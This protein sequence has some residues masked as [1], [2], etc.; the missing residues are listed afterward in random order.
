MKHINDGW[1][2]TTCAYCGVGCGVEARPNING[3]LEIR[4]DKEHPANFGKLCT[5]G[6][7]L[8]ETVIT[9]GRLL[10]PTLKTP[11]GNETTDWENATTIV[12]E[13][14]K[15]TI[16]EFGPDSVAFYVSGQLLTE[17]YYL[18]N[19][20]IKGFIGTGNID[21][22]SR[23]CMASSVVGHKR[24]FGTDTVPVCYEDIEKSNLVILVGSNL[25]WCHPVIFQR[26]R[27]A[28][29]NNPDLKV[30]V[31]D[32]R[33]SETCAIADL[34]LPIK[35]G[36][37]VALFNGLLSYLD[38]TN[39]L[40]QNYIN[41]YTNNFENALSSAN[42]ESDIENKTGLSESQLMKFY[43]CFSST[44]K[45]ITIYSQG[46]NQ[47]TS[48][49][50]KVNSIINCHLATGKI[51]K[52]GTGPFSITGQPNA[53]GGRE[54]GALANTLASHMEFDN[55]EHTQLISEFWQTDRLATKAGLKAVDMFN[56]IE[57][58]K[59]KAIWI[60]AT[61]PVISLPNSEKIKSALETCP[62]V[63]VSDCIEETETT[64]LAD[65]VLPAQGWSE[66]SGTVT[67][68]ERRIS[69]QRRVMPSPGMAKP[70]WWIINQVAR[71]MGFEKSF[72][73]R[74]EGEI[75][76]E[77]ARLSTVGNLN[78]E[79][80]FN[81]IGLTNLDDKGYSELVPQ[82]WPVLALQ[83]S[84]VNQ[85]MFVDNLFFTSNKKANF[86]PTNY[87]A[88]KS[89]TT[90]DFPMLLNSGRTRDQ[91]HTM[92]RTG[93]SESL[94]DHS[95]EPY[96]LISK[97]S[98][99]LYRIEEGQ[100]VKLT[101]SVGSCEAKAKITNAI[102]DHQLFMPI[103]WTNITA[104]N[105]KPCSLIGS[106]NDDISGQPEFKHTPVCI[107]PMHS[108]SSAVFITRTPVN[109][110]QFEY[111]SRQKI[112]NGYLYRI[113]SSLQVEELHQLL[114]GLSNNSEAKVLSFDN[115]G[116]KRVVALDADKVL[117]VIQS[118]KDLTCIDL[119]Q[120]I[121]IFEQQVDLLNQETILAPNYDAY[122]VA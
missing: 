35:S 28:K 30:I 92:S 122:E 68:S 39:K 61:N 113:E 117:R 20:L 17:D 74:H 76:A 10:S 97:N 84:P 101:S 69:R 49:S 78:N 65:L 81:L 63:V 60:M 32:P 66:K 85:R 103:H 2:K 37:D 108:I 25:A 120:L 106:Q 88:P 18:A 9:D 48:G 7:A 51:G 13:R 111:W 26:L 105:S 44:E 56:A 23:L 47:S 53:M 64:R 38:Q 14:F 72:N 55:T 91:W 15:Q 11:L 41:N 36:G 80:D 82:Q 12:A 19:K 83:N 107:E 58:G 118:A 70:D 57:E 109:F 110:N 104:K 43:E 21:S 112:S 34:H 22:N 119:S 52:L 46:V 90:A 24:A 4:G 33:E 77:Y 54:V 27:I 96:V 1:I 62:F 42:E 67:N 75:F 73:Y 31:I 94:G 86:V 50:D 95:P 6:I 79:R 45:V 121:D 99:Q 59:I 114:H 3:Q 100:R 40:D 87:Q 5:K 98:A 93:L 89:K 29:Q 71:K 16:E 115:Q 116:G 102:N 8:G